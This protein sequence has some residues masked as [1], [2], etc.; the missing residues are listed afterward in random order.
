MPLY[1][2]PDWQT[3][4][5]RTPAT[6][7]LDKH[8]VKYQLWPYEHNPQTSSFGLEAAQALGLN[9]EVVFKTL[10]SELEPSS[11]LRSHSKNK[12][13]VAIIPVSE[14]LS[15]KA[16]A[17]AARVKKA[18]MAQISDAERSSGYV[19]GGISPF[20]QKNQLATYIDETAEL[21]EVIYV[22][23]GQ[24]GLD[25]S[26]APNDLIELLNAEIASLCI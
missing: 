26:I 24:R 19:A 25:I 15:F 10:V 5:V 8:D 13:A 1:V 18:K 2:Q 6:R 7:F 17:K 11:D 4:E 3:G 21:C 16:L 12:L 20:G 14:Q 23:G 22:S 9:P